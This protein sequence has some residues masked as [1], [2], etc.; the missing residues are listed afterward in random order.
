MP[1]LGEAWELLFLAYNFAPLVFLKKIL[2]K[3]NAF[4]LNL[5]R[6]SKAVKC[7]GF[8]SI[9]LLQPA[10]LVGNLFKKVSLC[11]NGARKT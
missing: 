9:F 11:L 1:M 2:L 10:Y 8:L 6:N 5:S 3:F 4:S 7:H